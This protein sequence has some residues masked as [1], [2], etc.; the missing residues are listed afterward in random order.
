V[1]NS[2]W[3]GGIYVE[4]ALKVTFSDGNRDLVLHYVSATTSKDGFVAV[5][6]AAASPNLPS[7]ADYSVRY[8]SLNAERRR[9]A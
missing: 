5:L 2:G 4:P 9:I 8:L 3:G 1:L 6:A 7:G